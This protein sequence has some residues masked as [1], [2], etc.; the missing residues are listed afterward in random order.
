MYTC[1]VWPPECRRPHNVDFWK[2]WFLI[3]TI[4]NT[5]SYKPIGEVSVYDGTT[6]GND[7]GLNSHLYT[8]S[9]N[10]ADLKKKHQFWS[11]T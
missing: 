6:S 1:S 11:K 10:I 9:E 5:S 4:K 2:N 8:H 3:P 7:A